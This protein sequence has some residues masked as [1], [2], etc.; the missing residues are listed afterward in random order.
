MDISF[1]DVFFYT[2]APTSA[3]SC[4]HEMCLY[5]APT[6]PNRFKPSALSGFQT[7]PPTPSIYEDARSNLDDFEFETSKRFNLSGFTN[8]MDE[9]PFHHM[10]E[11][12]QVPSMAF[13]DELFCDGKVMPLIKPLKLPPRLLDNGNG[14]KMSTQSST[15]SSPRSPGSVFRLPFS[16]HSLWNDD[17]DPF[18]AALEKVKAEKTRKPKGKHG[19]QKEPLKKAPRNPNLLSEPKGL[20]FPKQM[21]LKEVVFCKRKRKREQI[22]KLLFRNAHMDK[23]SS[24]HKLEALMKPSFMRKLGLKPGALSPHWDKDERTGDMTKMTLACYKP[25]LF[26]CLGSGGKYVK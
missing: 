20:L 15:V 17:F 10:Q 22:M 19:L 3:R 26:L 23:T 13:A 11:H 6:S 7:E 25:R 9:N 16:S 21:S 1:S 24:K 14:N 5:S 18:I 8:Q 2:S 12:I 4:S